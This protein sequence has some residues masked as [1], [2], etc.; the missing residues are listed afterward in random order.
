[1]QSRRT[2]V[3]RLTSQ[4]PSADLD[5]QLG[6]NVGTKK[7]EI[8]VFGSNCYEFVRSLLCL[9]NNIVLNI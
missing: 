5:E 6:K 7:V 2:G 4:Q 3:E 1:M 9:T 8:K